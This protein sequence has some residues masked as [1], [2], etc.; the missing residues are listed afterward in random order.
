[1]SI[2]FSQDIQDILFVMENTVVLVF[3]TGYFMFSIIDIKY[4]YLAENIREQGALKHPSNTELRI[5]GQCNFF[6]F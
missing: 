5:V 2:S 4:A 1:M 3:A 6:S